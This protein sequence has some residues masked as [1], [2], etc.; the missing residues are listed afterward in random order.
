MDQISREIDA[1]GNGEI[2]FEEFLSI[3]KSDL[4]RWDDSQRASLEGRKMHLANFCEKLHK[5]FLREMQ[6]MDDREIHT[7]R[8][9]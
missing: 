4:L 9:F 5:L 2:D 1:D 7:I 8:L 3:M 6:L